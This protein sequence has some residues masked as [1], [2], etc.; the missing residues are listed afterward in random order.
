MREIWESA[1]MESERRGRACRLSRDFPEHAQ[2]IKTPQTSDS[3]SFA[4]LLGLDGLLELFDDFRVHFDLILHSF[5]ILEVHEETVFFSRGGQVTLQLLDLVLVLLDQCLLGQLLIHF[6]FVGDV[7]RSGR[8]RDGG[9]SFARIQF[10]IDRPSLAKFIAN[11]T[12][13]R[14]ERYL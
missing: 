7:F 1:I 4:L 9:V 3:L 8:R 5:V 10:E 6:R 13:D 12:R 14:A 2:T 11:D